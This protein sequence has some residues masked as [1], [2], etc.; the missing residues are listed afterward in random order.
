MGFG[1]AP[2]WAVPAP[3]LDVG[4]WAWVQTRVNRP[5]LS[6]HAGG[7]SSRQERKGLWAWLTRCVYVSL[8]R[9][10]DVSECKDRFYSNKK[11]YP[12]IV[13]SDGADASRRR[14]EV[15]AGSSRV[16]ERAPQGTACISPTR[17]TGLTGTKSGESL[18][19]GAERGEGGRYRERSMLASLDHAIFFWGGG[20][21]EPWVGF[22]DITPY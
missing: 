9:K 4:A 21:V 18:E 6:R 1:G 12:G 14:L 13:F 7:R 2:P 22:K 11:T 3:D 8:A 16:F 10:L 15:E 20:R 5:A 19:D 17:E